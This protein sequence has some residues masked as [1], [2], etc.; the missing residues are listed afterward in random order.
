MEERPFLRAPRPR[1]RF[2]R[3]RRRR[4]SAAFERVP[5]WKAD[6]GANLGRGAFFATTDFGG[7]DGTPPSAWLGLD[8]FDGE[9]LAG[10]ALRRITRM[11][12]YAYVAH[13]PV[14]TSNPVHWDSWKGW[15]KYPRN[16]IVGGRARRLRRLEARRDIR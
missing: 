9:P 15:Y 3:V 5:A 8:A 11:A 12:C 13:I 7:A 10:V 6:D 1:V 4:R 2:P 14:A 16:P